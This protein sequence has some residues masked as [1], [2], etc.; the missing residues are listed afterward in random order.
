MIHLATC[1]PSSGHVFSIAFEHGVVAVSGVFGLDNFRV[2]T[3]SPLNDGQWHTLEVRVGFTQ[4][5]VAVFVDDSSVASASQEVLWI[6]NL[7]VWDA[8]VSVGTNPVAPSNFFSG[9]DAFVHA[10]SFCHSLTAV[11]SS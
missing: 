1:S 9:Y 4:N 5:T 7:T 2:A 6:V 11:A 10:L 3:P 8:V